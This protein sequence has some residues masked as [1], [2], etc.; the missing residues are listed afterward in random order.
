MVY[1]KNAGR[2]ANFLYQ[3]FAAYGYAKKHGLEFT[4]PNTD[5]GEWHPIY[6]RHLINPNFNPQLPTMLINETQHSYQE[7]PFNEQWANVNICLQGYFQSCR[8]WDFCIDEIRSLTRFNFDPICN[9]VGIHIRRG[10]FLLYPEKHILCPPSYYS[11]CML[12]LVSTGHLI[13]KI[14][15]FS[16]DIPWCRDTFTEDGIEFSEGKT[17]EEDFQEL[18]NCQYIIA[19]NSSFS[20]LAGTL[21]AHPNRVV[22][23]PHEDVYFHKKE[24]LNVSTMYP[25][26]FIKLKF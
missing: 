20:I 4:V 12:R 22:F 8:Y 9:K 16:D 15:I 25:P 23:A 5:R 13:D 19:A 26:D 6:L 21:N 1:F 7:L 2:L 10:D 14:K 17:P 3:C 18:M 11:Q 24:N